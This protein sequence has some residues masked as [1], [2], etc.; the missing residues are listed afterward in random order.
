MF[1]FIKNKFSEDPSNIT[2]KER[3]FAGG[4]AGILG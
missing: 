3:F 2:I 4:I 1:D